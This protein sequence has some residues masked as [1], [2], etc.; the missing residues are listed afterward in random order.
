MSK[1]TVTSRE[2]RTKGARARLKPRGEPYWLPIDQG[3]HLGLRRTRRGDRWTARLYLPE[4]HR[5]AKTT[6]GRTA[7]DR[8][9][10]GARFLDFHQAQDATLR[11]GREQG[12][13]PASGAV[14]T[15]QDLLDCY[16]ME[17]IEPHRRA[18]AGAAG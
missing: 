3:I 8:P 1:A 15:V 16:L 14:K 13:V 11:W 9:A 4:K 17:H 18:V 5:Y 10:D 6:L 2:L 12:A 7:D